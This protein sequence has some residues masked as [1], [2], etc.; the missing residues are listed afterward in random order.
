MATNSAWG[1]D[2][3]QQ[4]DRDSVGVLSLVHDRGLVQDHAQVHSRERLQEC[5]WVHVFAPDLGSVHG[6][7][8]GTEN[9]RPSDA[10]REQEFAGAC[11]CATWSMTTDAKLHV[12]SV[13]VLCGSGGLASEV[14]PCMAKAFEVERLPHVHGR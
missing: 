8:V 9:G 2:R 12:F 5:E 4:S 10:R 6:P 13:S 7:N 1:Q 11:M 3:A 14:R